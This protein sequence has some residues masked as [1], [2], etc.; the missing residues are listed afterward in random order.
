MTTGSMDKFSLM[1]W[2]LIKKGK[3]IGFSLSTIHRGY[4]RYKALGHLYPEFSKQL[5]AKKTQFLQRIEHDKQAIEEVDRML[6]QRHAIN[7]S[8]GLSIQA[9]FIGL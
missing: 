6:N 3:D 1:N 4:Q 5:C 2:L 7:K 8:L 9:P